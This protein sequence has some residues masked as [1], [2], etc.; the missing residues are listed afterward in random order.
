[1]VMELSDNRRWRGEFQRRM[2]D[3]R[4]GDIDDLEKFGHKVK[5]VFDSVEQLLIPGNLIPSV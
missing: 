5:V 3:V 2:V 1:M 4:G